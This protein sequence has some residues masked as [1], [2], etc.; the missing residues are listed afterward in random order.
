MRRKSSWGLFLWQLFGCYG[1]K[2]HESFEG[3]DENLDGIR[4][5]VPNTYF[6]IEVTTVF[7]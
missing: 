1:K 3:L 4:E 5:M 2:G 7:N 6:D